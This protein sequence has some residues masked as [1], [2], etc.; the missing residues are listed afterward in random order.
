MDSIERSLF[1]VFLYPFFLHMYFTFISSPTRV[2]VRIRTQETIPSQVRILPFT[3][4]F[5]CA[6]GGVGV[7]CWY[8]LLSLFSLSGQWSELMDRSAKDRSQLPLISHHELDL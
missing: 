7:L 1:K 8:E 2:T 4:T 5:R 3:S 6:G